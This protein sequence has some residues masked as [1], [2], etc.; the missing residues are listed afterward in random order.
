MPTPFS[1]G[2]DG[3][4]SSDP[5]GIKIRVSPCSPPMKGGRLHRLERPAAAHTT[6]ATP[7]P[8]PADDWGDGSWTVDCSCGIT[9]DDGEEM[10]SCDECNVWVH[11]RCARYVRGV[12]I[13]F[14]CHNCKAKR[15]PS[16]ADEAEVAELLAELPTHRPRPLYR[17]WADVPLPSR[18]HVHGLPG[19]TDAA[20]FRGATPSPVFSAALWR[21]A[22]YVPKRF[23]FRYCEFPYWADD[24]DGANALFALA[25][26]K[27]KEKA[28]TR[29]PLRLGAVHKDKN[30]VRTLSGCGDKVDGVEHSGGDDT[31]RISPPSDAK[32]RGASISALEADTWCSDC[33]PKRDLDVLD[34]ED[35]EINMVNSDLHVAKKKMASSSERSGDKKCSVSKEVTGTKY[36]TKES[37]RLVISSGVET[38]PAVADQEV[39]SRF[40]KVEGSIYEGQIEDNQNIG[41]QAGIRSTTVVKRDDVKPSNE[42]APSD[43]GP[44]KMHEGEGLQKQSNQT[45]S[46]LQVVVGVLDLQNNQSESLNIKSEA[47]HDHE[48]IEAIQFISDEH[49]SG[50]QGQGDTASFS[51]LERHP[52]KLASDLV[53]QHPKSE[54]QNQ[55]HTIPEHPNSNLDTAKV[56]TASSGPTSTPFELSCSLLSKEP[57]S[58]G[59]TVRLIKKDQ[60]RLVSSAD[61]ENDFARVSEESSQER[62]RS[63]EK[64]Q[65]KGFVPSAPKST[66]AS[67][68]HVSSVKHR[69]IVPKEQSQKTATE[70]ST[71]PRSLQGEVTLLHSRNKGMPLSFYQRKDKIHHRSIHI[72]QETSSCSA[73]TELQPTEK[74]ASLSDEQLALLLHQQLNSSPRVPRVPRCHQATTMQMLHSTGATVFSKRSSAHGGRDQALVLKKRS[75]DDAWR[76]N[77]D[78]KRTGKVSCVERR[79][80]DCST[81][82]AL[83]VK[84]SCKFAENVESEQQNRGICSTGATTDL[85]KDAPVD[86]SVSRDLPG[87]ID[88]IISKNVNITYGELCDT[89]CQHWR[90][91]SKHN[92]ED[93]AYPSFLHAVNDCLRNR[94]DWAHLVDQ[95]PMVRSRPSSSLSIL[96][97]PVIPS[98][99]VVVTRTDLILLRDNCFYFC[100][101]SI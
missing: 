81:E 24:K 25:R 64:G 32:K 22:G 94:N 49:K 35:A 36:E 54:T 67:R 62:T 1:R 20:L 68:T 74:T 66:Q 9:Y 91:L 26:E 75:K 50:K 17:R 41:L 85:G 65:L 73:S 39:H 19:G 10:V 30:Y 70:G 23:G 101:F 87:L 47:T 77:D 8:A 6:T 96:S 2:T 82:R 95:A 61:S 28:E 86:S 79:H 55:M 5:K 12:H 37:M 56:C 14:S 58:E 3:R 89:I 69:L 57:S 13:S 43:T 27:R 98:M 48:R 60:T 15:A 16:S 72:T 40:V 33:E 21:C 7:A 45:S 31:K 84:D 90:D 38:T 83:A 63:S 80:R 92:V 42:D 97:T 52:S 71:P 100:V 93:N 88:Q 76:D 34:T 99:S 44:E 53:S 51:I 18:V 4:G 59:T 11:T 78:T 46:N 29:F